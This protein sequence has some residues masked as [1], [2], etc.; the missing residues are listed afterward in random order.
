MARYQSVCHGCVEQT[1]EAREG[2]R[3]VELFVLTKKSLHLALT[4]GISKS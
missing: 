4:N 1:S 2:W 3:E